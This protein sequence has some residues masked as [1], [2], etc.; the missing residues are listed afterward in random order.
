[1]V[2]SGWIEKVEADLKSEVTLL[3]DENNAQVKLGPYRSAFDKLLREFRSL[4]PLL[5]QIKSAYDAALD[6]SS[7]EVAKVAPLQSLVAT[8]AEDCERK[9]LKMGQDE[10]DD[11]IAMRS[12]NQRLKGDIRT[13]QSEIQDLNVQVAK[14]GE[15]LGNTY[16]QYRDEKCARRLLISDMNDQKIQAEQA[17]DAKSGGQGQEQLDPVHMK[18]ALEQARKDLTEAQ[19]QITKMKIEYAEVVPR[20]AHEQMAQEYQQTQEQRDRLQKNLTRLR[21]EFT[22]LRETYEQVSSERDEAVKGLLN[23]N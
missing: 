10:R 1:M 11:L 12:E 14:L 18:L 13:A 7:K 6:E 2:R 21:D 17:I 16:R 22:I 23:K 19:K 4:K 5:V 20:Q 15:E 3:G 8:V 9:M